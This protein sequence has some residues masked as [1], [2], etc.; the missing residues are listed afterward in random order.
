MLLGCDLSFSTDCMP[1]LL[2]PTRSIFDRSGGLITNQ[3]DP[4]FH[5]IVRG[6]LYF[7]ISHPINCCLLLF[8]DIRL[9]SLNS[10]IENEPITLELT[11]RVVTILHNA[12]LQTPSQEIVCIADPSL[13]DPLDGL[14]ILG[15]YTIAVLGWTPDMLHATLKPTALLSLRSPS[16]Q[17]LGQ[18][19]SLLNMWRAFYRAGRLGWTAQHHKAAEPAAT[20]KCCAPLNAPHQPNHMHPPS[21]HVI[22]PGEL[23]TYSPGLVPARRTPI[24]NA[25]AAAAE[26]AVAAEDAA[27]ALAR[28]RVRTAVRLRVSTPATE[29]ALERRGVRSVALPFDFCSAVGLPPDLV[30]AFARAVYPTNR[31]GTVATGAAAVDRDDGHCGAVCAGLSALHLMARHGFAAAEAAAWLRLS[32]PLAA[33]R[34]AAAAPMA[35][36]VAVEREQ[37]S[38]LAGPLASRLDGAPGLRAGGEEGGGDRR[39]A[40]LR[41]AVYRVWVQG[42]RRRQSGRRLPE[43]DYGAPS[44]SAAS[45]SESADAGG[46]AGR[47]D[48]TCGSRRFAI[49]AAAAWPAADGGS[50]GRPTRLASRATPARAATDCC[51]GAVQPDSEP[52]N[53]F[54]SSGPS[55]NMPPP[56]PPIPPNGPLR[57]AWAP[58]PSFPAQSGAGGGAAARKRLPLVA[59]TAA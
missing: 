12:V 10:V 57:S 20:T 36:L 55:R 13:R 19:L 15:C 39:S 43:S 59:T 31:G 49:P 18:D 33:G 32:A 24:N 21:V 28:M 26:D 34:A 45:D 58:T 54:E 56:F 50:D 22:V 8:R 9:F 17:L 4:S 25:A 40:A 35:Y 29:A 44:E 47:L 37:L 42:S 2:R 30:S 23:I 3:S 5:P 11:Y 16:S 1:E 14:F 51:G 38:A 52:G 27:A 41:L 53:P 7:A 6:R 46:A 48:P